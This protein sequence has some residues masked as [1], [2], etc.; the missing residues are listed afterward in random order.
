MKSARAVFRRRDLI[1]CFG[2][3]LARIK[4]ARANDIVPS[5]LLHDWL[6]ALVF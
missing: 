2:R 1:S 6:P 4:T 5:V 3:R